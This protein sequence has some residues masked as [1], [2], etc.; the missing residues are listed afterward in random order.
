MIATLLRINWLNLKRDVVALGLTFVL[1]I[2]FFS[3]FAVIFGG[4][5]S[6]SGG[7][8]GPS[9][10]KVIIVDL[11][12]SEVSQRLISALVDLPALTVSTHPRP[13]DD[14]PAPYT[15]EQAHGLVRRGKYPAAVIIPTGFASTFGRFDGRGSAVEVIH[16]PANPLA[17]HTVSGLLQAAAMRAAPDILMT[18]GLEQLEAAGGILTPMQRNLI[19]EFIPRI[20]GQADIDSNEGSAPPTSESSSPAA[21]TGLVTVKLIDAGEDADDPDAAPRSIVAYYAAGIGVMFLLFS[22]A[23]GAG[24]TLLEEAERGTLERLLSTHINM[25]TLLLGHWL[26]F[27]LT[28]VAQVTSMFVWAAVVFGL[29]L[30]T[31]THMIAF[32]IMT[33]ATAGAAAAF[34]IVLAALCTTRAQLGGIS[35]IVILIMSALGGSMVPRFI[36]PDFM[37]TTALFTFNGW[38]LD[39]YLKIFWYEEPGASVAQALFGLWPQVCMLIAMTCVFLAIARTLAKRWQTA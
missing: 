16:D 38:A 34:G 17:V 15:R 32:G 33:I 21:F 5:G 6:G 27:A 29:D 19:E 2:V 14:K 24:G 18:R 3:I 11:D 30:W 39:G 31:P 37:N 9:A 1:P 23:N 20:R 28:G 10:T 12:Q 35:T 13:A 8:G 22:M 25:G 4:A 26:F 36:M 7:N